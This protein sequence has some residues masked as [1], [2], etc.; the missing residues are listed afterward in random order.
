M[1]INIKVF[2]ENERYQKYYMY[3]EVIL[4]NNDTQPT[5]TI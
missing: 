2:I 4:R 5:R 3:F 1:I